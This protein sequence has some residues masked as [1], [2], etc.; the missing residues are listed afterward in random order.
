MPLYAS[1]FTAN[2]LSGTVKVSAGTANIRI[3]LAPF[4]LEGNK[5]FVLKLRK[6][7]VTGTVIATTPNISIADTSTF[8]SLTAN[9]ATVNEGDLVAFSLVTTNVVNGATVYYSVFPASANVTADDFVANTGSTVITNNAALFTLKANTNFAPIDETGENFRVQLRT[10]DVTTGNIVYT[11]SNITILD[12]DKTYN[13]ITFAPPSF[14]VTESS[15]IIFTFLGTNIPLGTTFYYET[16]GNATVTANT[17]SFVLNSSSNTFTIS[18]GAVPANQINAFTVN[19][20]TGSAAGPI[21]RTSDTVYVLDSS[22]AYTTATGGNQVYIDNGYKVHVFLSSNNFAISRA[23]VGNFANINYLAIGGGGSGAGMYQTGGGGAGGALLSNVLFNS[24]GTYT[25]T[26]GSGAAGGQQFVE[27]TNGGN[28]TISGPGLST[29]TAFGGGGSAAF[30]VTTAS[31]SGGSGGGAPTGSTAPGIGA[32]TPG[33]GFPGGPSAPIGPGAGRAGAGGGAGGAGQPGATQANQGGIGIT[34][35]ITGTSRSY[36]GGGGGG[37]YGSPVTDGGD[38]YTGYG[39][40]SGGGYYGGAGPS[41]R[42]NAESGNVNTGG[43][44]GGTERSGT[45]VGGSGGSGIVVLKYP[46]VEAATYTALTTSSPTTST[47]TYETFSITFTLSTLNL[48][49]N[50]LLYYTTVGNVV[51]TNFV[52]GNTGSFRSTANVTTLTLT[53][54]SN[55]PANEER[56][57]QL[58]VRADSLTDPVALTSNV[59]TIKDAALQPKASTVEY[60]VVAG[61]GGGGSAGEQRGGGGGGGGGGFRMASGFSITAGSPLT[62]TVGAGGNGGTSPSRYSEVIGT[63]GSPS[64]FSSITSVGGGVGG[65]AQSAAPGGPGGSGGGCGQGSYTGGTGTPGQGNPGGGGSVYAGAG[66]GAGAAGGDSGSEGTTGAAGALAFNGNY[67]AGGGAGAGNNPASPINAGGIGGGG[68]GDSAYAYTPGDTNT[69]GGGGG[70]RG[71]SNLQYGAAG[72]NGGSGIVI[73][74]YPSLFALATTTGGANVTY[75]N[76]NVVYTFTSSGTITFP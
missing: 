23:G 6:D 75:A 73:I 45:G 22:L 18:A 66:G 25:I 61:G 52:S 19:L 29:I 53:A 57:F 30:G 36:A 13:I 51:S 4:A 26:V 35:S 7:S 71:G 1:N 50:T 59:F 11:T 44:G 40:G 76:A 47:F 17:G 33:Q 10:T 68:Q 62:V 64:V 21:V 65:I 46:F 42:V 70:G 14:N 32:G 54:N 38:A 37:A 20:R 34:S 49:N 39:G 58:Q 69:G 74:R 24:A 72:G 27:G 41:T 43:G 2:S 60:L 9:T 8:V 67:Y 16:T 12:T 5:Q 28:T 48:A 31:Y 15:S 55:I 3:A 56:F 63:Q